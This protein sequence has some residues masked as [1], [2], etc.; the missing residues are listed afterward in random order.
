MDGS[1]LTTEEQVLGSDTNASDG[2][3]AENGAFAIAGVLKPYQL[4]DDEIEPDELYGFY[5]FLNGA[6]AL[7]YTFTPVDGSDAFSI[8]KDVGVR[9][10]DSPDGETKPAVYEFYNV[11][12]ADTLKAGSS[13]NVTVQAYDRNNQAVNGAVCEFTIDMQEEE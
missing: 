5:R 9:R 7:E 3:Q 10:I 13:Y 11:F 8:K 1:F 2:W 6:D 12:P 4:Q